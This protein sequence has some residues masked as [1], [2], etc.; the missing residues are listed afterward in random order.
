MVGPLTKTSLLMQTVS[1]KVTGDPVTF[2]NFGFWILGFGF[3]IPV[4]FKIQNPKPKI[5]NLRV[6][7]LH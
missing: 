6:C 3:V 4:I 1:R 2:F 7:N 5:Q